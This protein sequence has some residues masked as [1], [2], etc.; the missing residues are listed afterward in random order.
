MG[1]PK[2]R[3]LQVAED[4]WR[5][6][7]RIAAAR[8][9]AAVL[10]TRRAQQI[11]SDVPNADGRYAYTQALKIENAALAEYRRV[12]EIFAHLTLHGEFPLEDEE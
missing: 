12:L 7:T 11:S 6:A 1:I 4:H 2:S 8:Y 9:R 5:D 10:A 3:D